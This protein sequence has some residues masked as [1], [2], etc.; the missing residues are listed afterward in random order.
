MRDGSSRPEI[1]CHPRG[2]SW[3]RTVVKMG[4][5]GDGRAIRRCRRHRGPNEA[6]PD[7][8]FTADHG[9]AAPPQGENAGMLIPH[10]QHGP[11]SNPSDRGHRRLGCSPSVEDRW[12]APVVAAHALDGLA[13]DQAVAVD[14]QG[15]ARGTRPPAAP[16]IRRAG[17]PVDRCGPPRISARPSGRAPRHRHQ[18]DA[19]ALAQ[20]L[21]WLR[22]PAPSGAGSRRPAGAGAGPWRWPRPAAPHRLEQVIHRRQLEGAHRVFVVGGGEDHR[23]RRSAAAQVAGQL[24]AVHHRH[25]GCR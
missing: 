18:Q 1:S 3:P 2:P 12:S 19:A 17:I 24:D 7:A 6:R 10:G 20:M 11:R 4:S 9:D 16:G 23:R 22:R 14:A 8:S 25:R 5:V 15:S 21:K 13:G